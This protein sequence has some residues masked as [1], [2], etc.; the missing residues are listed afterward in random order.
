MVRC[1]DTMRLRFAFI[2]LLSILIIIM[3]GCTSSNPED[4]TKD[5]IAAATS[6]LELLD[7]GK[8]DDA[9][10]ASA[11]EIKS[12]GPK[13]AFAKMME[14]TRAPLGKETSRTVKDKGYAKD[15]QNA[16]P[17]EYVQI[18]FDSSFA[19][20][21]SAT[22][23]VIVKKEPDGVWRVGQYSVNPE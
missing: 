1:G 6:W 15:P 9:W 4:A 2:S 20:A 12:V 19:N 3:G 18:H 14:Q 17:G 5:G 21:K 11:D 10:A 13:D 8:Y 16:P 7:A 23:L 22:E